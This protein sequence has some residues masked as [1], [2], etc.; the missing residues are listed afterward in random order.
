MNTGMYLLAGAGLAGLIGG[1]YLY[2][3]K[4]FASK[5][6]I[7]TK[8][9]IGRF[10]LTGINLNITVTITNP[11]GVTVTLSS[12]IVK[13]LYK[14]EL[15]GQSQ[16]DVK[17]Y[18]IPGKGH[19]VIPITISLPYTA[20]AQNAPALLK[21]YRQAGTATIEAAIATTIDGKIPY[22]STKSFVI[23]KTT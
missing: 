16:D 17:D 4:T 9:S 7:S 21:E 13:L 19:T 22:S 23:G 2:R 14:G 20:L 18:K 5:V 15:I 10:S 1:T 6:Q 3:L 12:P 8:V 11:T